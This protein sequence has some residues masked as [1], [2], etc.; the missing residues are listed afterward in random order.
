MA[1]PSNMFLHNCSV[2]FETENWA[3]RV[4]TDIGQGDEI[5]MRDGQEHGLPNAAHLEPIIIPEE[6]NNINRDIIG[7]FMVEIV[8][9][10]LEGVP[11]LPQ[12]INRPDKP[13]LPLENSHDAPQNAENVCMRCMVT[14]ITD[15]VEQYIV[16]PC[17]HAW[18]CQACCRQLEQLNSTCPVCRRENI[19][20]HSICF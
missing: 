15:S 13:D 16:L 1:V 19:T 14:T 8:Q 2:C 3:L 17:G 4:D 18:V 5:P 7:D 10:Q 12:I 9:N 11:E 6:P 20:F